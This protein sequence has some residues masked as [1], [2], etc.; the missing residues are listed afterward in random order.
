MKQLHYRLQPLHHSL[1]PALHSF[2]K[3]VF[4]VKD[5]DCIGYTRMNEAPRPMFW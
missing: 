2:H 1:K 5:L 3:V 4:E